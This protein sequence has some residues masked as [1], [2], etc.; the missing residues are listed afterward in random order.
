MSDR[1][2]P[3]S[4]LEAEFQKAANEA[5]PLIDEQI[6]IAKEAIAKA[7]EISEK[8]GIPFYSSITPLSMPY[9]PVSYNEKFGDLDSDRLYALAQTD[10]PEYEGWQ[11]SSVCW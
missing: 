9:R 3:L 10:L 5:L 1:S 11:T 7:E 4:D 2:T 6:R 8:Y